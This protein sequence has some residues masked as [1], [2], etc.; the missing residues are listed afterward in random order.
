VPGFR[1]GRARTPIQRFYPHPPHQRLHVTAADLL[2]LGSQQAFDIALVEEVASAPATA[3]ISSAATRPAATG[4]PTPSSNVCP[5][6]AA[7]RIERPRPPWH[8]PSFDS[9]RHR[10]G[11]FH[12][13]LTSRPGCDSPAASTSDRPASTRTRLY[14]FVRAGSFILPFASFPGA[15]GLCQR[16]PP[17]ERPRYSYGAAYK[18]NTYSIDAA[19][20]FFN[21]GAFWMMNGTCVLPPESRRTACR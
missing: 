1:F 10:S 16:P 17:E 4:N 2:P 7:P 6:R 12:R 13:P 8:A 20:W 18:A 11:L 21:S 5:W 3:P 14:A 9:N 15:L 19:V